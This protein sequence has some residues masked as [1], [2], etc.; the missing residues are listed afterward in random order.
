VNAT[1]PATFPADQQHFDLQRGQLFVRRRDY[2]LIA[3]NTA[4]AATSQVATVTIFVQDTNRPVVA[5]LN[6][7]AGATVSI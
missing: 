2:L 5:V 6:P 1:I 4:G 3:T 7:A